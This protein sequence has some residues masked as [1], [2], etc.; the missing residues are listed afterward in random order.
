[1]DRAL[2]PALQGIGCV[3][4]LP[5]AAFLLWDAFVFRPHLA[6]IERILIQADQEDRKLTPTIHR[7]MGVNVRS[8]SGHVGSMLCWR[9]DPK[10]GNRHGTR[11]LW[12]LSVNLHFD[13]DERDALLA[14][15]SWNGT[16]Y[17]LDRYARRTYGRSLSALTEREAA[18][19]VAWTHSPSVYLRNPQRLRLRANYLLQQSG[20]L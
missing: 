11:A 7:L 17:G 5:V 1:M 20:A 6:E 8:V 3:F 9:L 2:K 14:A 4:G 13:V 12:A 15:L 18:M 10:P 19:V 16:D